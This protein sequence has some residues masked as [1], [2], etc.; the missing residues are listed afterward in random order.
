MLH[1]I[2]I[3]V[4][5]A[6]P[7]QGTQIVS[8][9]FAFAEFDDK[10]ACEAAAAEATKQAQGLGNGMRVGWHYLTCVPKSSVK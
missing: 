1:Y 3:A 10:A 5:V 6:S 7:M 9:G 2:L 4:F 8:P